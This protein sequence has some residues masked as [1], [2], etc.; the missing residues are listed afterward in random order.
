VLKAAT[1]PLSASRKADVQVAPYQ[2]EGRCET[3]DKRGKNRHSQSKQ[4][5]R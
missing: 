2:M 3:A 4:Q 1:C 5:R